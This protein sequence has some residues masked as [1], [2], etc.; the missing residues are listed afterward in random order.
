[1][2]FQLLA[3]LNED[4]T[5]IGFSRPMFVFLKPSSPSTTTENKAAVPTAVLAGQTTSQQQQQQQEQEAHDS[6][7]QNVQPNKRR[8]HASGKKGGNVQG[9]KPCAASA[10]SPR[11]T[12]KGGSKPSGD[13]DHRKQMQAEDLMADPEEE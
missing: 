6:A 5:A 10:C 8:R 4:S 12:G 1:M 11:Q 3:N 13:F 2:G 9:E 7:G